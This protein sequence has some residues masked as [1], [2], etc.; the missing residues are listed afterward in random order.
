M[1]IFQND[2]TVCNDGT[3]ARRPPGEDISLRHV[4]ENK[5]VILLYETREQTY[6]CPGHAPQ[7]QIRSSSEY[8]RNELSDKQLLD[9][10][11][12]SAV[13]SSHESAVTREF[14]NAFSTAECDSSMC[15]TTKR[16]KGAAKWIHRKRQERVPGAPQ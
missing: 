13:V 12:F 10:L 16:T 4:V 1:P 15:F 8:R 9:L 7:T 11:S 14:T 6:P 2:K 5:S 3:T